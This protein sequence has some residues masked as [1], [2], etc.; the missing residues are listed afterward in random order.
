VI[1][2]RSE[3][4]LERVEHAGGEVLF[5]LPPQA[6]VAI[7][8]EDSGILQ[9]IEPGSF[10]HHTLMPIRQQAQKRPRPFAP[11]NAGSPGSSSMRSANPAIQALVDQVDQNNISSTVQSLSSIYS[12]RATH[13]GAVTAQNQLEAQMQS[14]GVGTYLQNFGASYS[15]NVVGEIPGAVDPS[16]IVVIGAHYDSINN[17]GSMATAPGADDNASGTAG[18]WEIARILAA[19]G[20]FKYTLRFIAFSGEE[21]GLYGSEYAATVSDSA[22]EDIID[23]SSLAAGNPAVQIEFRLISDGGVVFG[24]WN[25]DDFSLVVL[26]PGCPPP[27]TYCDTSPNSVGPGAEIGYTG[28]TSLAA[29]DLALTVQGGPPSQF[30]LFYYGPNQISVPFGEGLR[31]VG[32]GIF[33]LNVVQLDGSGLGSYA[34]DV[35]N[36]P[37]P[38]GQILVD[39]IWNFQC[40]YRDPSGGP[41][42]FNVSDALEVIFCP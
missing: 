14:Y 15:K 35:T 8:P 5:R 27:T 7:R 18:V 34:L 26:N 24:G 39:S 10:M 30:A 6:L 32:G 37:Q 19:N 33:R 1:E 41:S 25:I 20:P 42:G 21:L 4:T 29:N 9:T 23:I 36:P 2:F 13:S 12:R 17:A 28:T 22:D 40:W 11:T 38:S 16:K 31:C 3:S